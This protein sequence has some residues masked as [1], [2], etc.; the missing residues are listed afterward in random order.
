LVVRAIRKRI[1]IA[2][3]DASHEIASKTNV[4]SAFQA[5]GLVP[6]HPDRP[7]KNL[8]ALIDDRIDRLRQQCPSFISGKTISERALQNVLG[9]YPSKIFPDEPE[10]V[11]ERIAQ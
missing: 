3:L 6:I 8:L 9:R 2:F 7:R 1:L 10:K 5:A 11:V 4:Q